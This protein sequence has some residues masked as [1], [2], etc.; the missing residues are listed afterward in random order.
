MPTGTSTGF[1]VAPHAPFPI[2]LRPRGSS[3]QLIATFAALTD[4]EAGTE[5]PLLCTA[6]VNR[7]QQ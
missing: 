6:I 3:V 1:F 4:E 5:I 2:A 7:T